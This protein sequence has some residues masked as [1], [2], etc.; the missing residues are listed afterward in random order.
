MQ[1]VRLLD[2]VYGLA[3]DVRAARVDGRQQ[4]ADRCQG[5]YRGGIHPQHARLQGDAAK[6]ALRRLLDTRPKCPDG[7]SAR[8][9]LDMWGDP[10]EQ[11]S[12]EFSGREIRILELLVD[13]QD[14]QIAKRLDISPAGV[15]Y[16][17]R[18]IF[19]KLGVRTRAG[20]VQRARSI[21]LLPEP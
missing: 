11:V 18:K 15:R 6:A 12:P 1:Q 21:G 8:R 14:K 7:A 5:C 4:L 13:S 9:L 17:L 20:A 16:H 2:M 19:R 3:D 10:G